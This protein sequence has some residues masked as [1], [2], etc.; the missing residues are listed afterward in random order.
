MKLK[1]GGKNS[2]L[3][4]GTN[5][6]GPKQESRFAKKMKYIAREQEEYLL[7]LE[8]STKGLTTKNG[9]TPIQ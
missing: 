7:N 5:T 1:D 3:K 4:E 2:A 8:E 9:D 6:A